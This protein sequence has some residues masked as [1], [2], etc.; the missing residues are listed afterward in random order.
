M[1]IKTRKMLTCDACKKEQTF[2]SIGEAQNKGWFTVAFRDLGTG[3]GHDSH[4]FAEVCS[5]ACGVK[6]LSS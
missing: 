5:T 3:E 2:D 4:Q 6:W 1:T